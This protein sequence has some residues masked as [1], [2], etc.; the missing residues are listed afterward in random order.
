ME[1][2]YNHHSGSLTGTPKPKKKVYPT[3][4]K[5]QN[6]SSMDIEN[7]ELVVSPTPA[8]ENSKNE[9]T[10]RNKGRK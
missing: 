10:Q 7:M 3:R 6:P 2:Y 8:H 9:R 1:T 5:E 4:A